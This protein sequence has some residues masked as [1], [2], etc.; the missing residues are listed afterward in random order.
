MQVQSNTFVIRQTSDLPLPAMVDQLAE[1]QAQ[2]AVLEALEKNLKA[3]L[4]RSGLT[5]VC[6]MTSRAVVTHVPEGV[7]VSWQKVANFMEVPQSVIDK[8]SAKRDPYDKVT[9]YGYN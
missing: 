5:E 6:G 9:L 8:F 4:I 7:S 1:L 2:I 3:A